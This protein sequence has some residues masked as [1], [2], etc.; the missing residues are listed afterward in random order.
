MSSQS[1]TATQ[2]LSPSFSQ[3]KENQ[4]E[5]HFTFSFWAHHDLTPPPF[6][7]TSHDT[8]HRHPGKTCVKWLLGH[9]LCVGASSAHLG[10][11][12]CWSYGPRLPVLL[13]CLV[14]SALPSPRPNSVRPPLWTTRPLWHQLPLIPFGPSSAQQ[15]LSSPALWTRPTVQFFQF[16]AGRPDNFT[17]SKLNCWAHW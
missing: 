4:A 14:L 15:P 8:L 16:G 1:P 11:G 7:T 5:W 9:G 3:N 17:D 2:L 13:L 12:P 10:P 6:C